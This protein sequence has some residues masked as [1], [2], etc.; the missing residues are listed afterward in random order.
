M[1]PQNLFSSARLNFNVWFNKTVFGIRESSLN[2]S[3]YFWIFPNILNYSKYFCCLHQFMSKAANSLPRLT[4]NQ[5][6]KWQKGRKLVTV[7]QL[8]PT[9]RQGHKR[10]FSDKWTFLLMFTLQ[11]LEHWVC[12]KPIKLFV[13]NQIGLKML[14]I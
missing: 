14:K 5:P 2:Y 13:R 9:L 3:K 8:F 12:Q 11:V 7:F 6:Q 10:L 1:W 4:K